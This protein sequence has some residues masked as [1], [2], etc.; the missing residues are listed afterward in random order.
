MAL[1]SLCLGFFALMLDSTVT[2]V[3]LP[4]IA[5]GLHTT[6][7]AA[8]WVNSGYLF[9]YAV[10][11]LIAGRLGDRYGPRRVYL[12]GL[13][14]FTLGSL[15]CALAP[16]VQ[17]LIA[18]RVAQGAGAALMTPQCLTVIRALYQPPRLAIALGT[19][20]SVGGAAAAAG[21][22]LGG[23]LVAAGGWPAV[24]WLNVPLGAVVAAAVLAFVPALP[25]QA[26]R[27]PVW[28]VCANAVGV[29]ALVVGIQGTGAASPRALAVP[30]WLLAVAGALLVAAVVWLQRRDGRRAL[31]PVALLRRRGFVTAA[32]GAGAAAFCAGSAPI[33]LM[34]YLQQERGLGPT[35]A[36]LTLVPMGIVC[37]LGAPVSARLNNRIGPRAVAAT[38]SLALTTSIGTAALLVATG[39]PVP[40]LTATLALYGVANSFV[41]SPFSIAAVTAVP[42]DAV[43]AASGSFNA[44]KQL[45]AVLG[46]AVSAILLAGFGDATTLAG[47]AAAGLLSLLAAALLDVPIPAATPAATPVPTGVA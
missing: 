5:T 37:L 33:P 4:A 30:R 2:A 45:G 24:F 40:A 34:L 20:G 28:A 42:P 16:T 27:V 29:L 36:A 11:L 17:A 8:M 38:G 9:A 22:L 18:W 44:V 7:T 26:A 13:A 43:G 31:L 15:L 1:A 25:R 23:P 10:P 19:W 47:L 41:W 32:W 35:R 21:P 14:A 39:A 46:S 3:A 6:G 12:G